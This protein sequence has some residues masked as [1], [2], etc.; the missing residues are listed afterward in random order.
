MGIPVE[1]TVVQLL[2]TGAVVVTAA[3]I[4]VRAGV[5]RVLD[6]LRDRSWR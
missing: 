2:P 6:H 1:E 3:A 4:G 5:G